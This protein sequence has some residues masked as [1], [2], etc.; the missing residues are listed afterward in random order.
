MSNGT[1]ADV[2]SVVSLWRYPIKSMM[3]EELGTSIITERGL[4]G[5]RAYALM[6]P[7]T[8]KVASAKN[9]RKWPNL[10]DFRANYSETP[11]LGEKTPSVRITAPDGEI[12]A[13]EQSDIDE[14]L[15]ARLGR[16]VTLVAAAPDAPTLEEYWP[17]IEGLDHRET[18]TDEEMPSETFFDLAVVHVLTTA[19]INRLRELYPEGRIEVRRF[20]PN[21]VVEPPS[22][23]RGFVENSWVGGTLNLGDEVVLRITRPCP[24]CVMTTRPQGDLPQDV[25]ILRTVAQHNETHVGVYASVLKGGKI[26]RGDTVWLQSA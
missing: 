3:G 6:D 1:K 13:S 12:V 16:E 14:T 24:R 22:G 9:P 18:V 17:D 20:R 23:E 15:S 26:S 7:S 25:G 2:G 5:D 10:F 4:L 21:I 8:E 19:T 11:R